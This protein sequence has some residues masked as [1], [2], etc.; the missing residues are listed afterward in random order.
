M[1][2]RPIRGCIP[3]R[4]DANANINEPSHDAFIM[5]ILSMM[6]ACKGCRRGWKIMWNKTMINEGNG[7][8]NY[9]GGANARDVGLV[10]ILPCRKGRE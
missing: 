6:K 8:V 2:N 5:V 7:G 9:V 1:W 3:I 4:L 10:K